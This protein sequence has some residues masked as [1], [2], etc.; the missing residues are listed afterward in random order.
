MS[1]A[2]SYPDLSDH[3]EGNVTP[4]ASGRHSPPIL[5]PPPTTRRTR[6]SPAPTTAELRNEI[7]SLRAIVT[8]LQTRRSRTPVTP[9]ADEFLNPNY[10]RREGTSFSE[11]SQNYPRKRPKVET[12][13]KFDGNVA[14]TRD[15]IVKLSV[16]FALRA[17]DFLDDAEKIAYVFT[18]LEGQAAKWARPIFESPHHPYRKDFDL[19][20]NEFR[21]VFG[22][23][24][25]VEMAEAKLFECRQRST[26]AM[27]VAEFQSLS[28]DVDWNEPALV[29]AFTRGLRSGI[30]DE[31]ARIGRPNKLADCITLACTLDNRLTA[32]AKEISNRNTTGQSSSNTSKNAGQSHA[33]ASSKS[34]IERLGIAF[35][36]HNKS[37]ASRISADT[38]PSL[39]SRISTD[40]KKSS[41]PKGPLSTEEKERRANEG[42]CF[43]CGMKGHLRIDCPLNAKTAAASI[44]VE[45]DGRRQGN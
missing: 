9:N 17:D 34:L 36:E 38:K 19:F 11:S 40:K 16:I 41:V 21:H 29:A 35:D 23:R 22:D 45:I 32:R 5:V 14:K 7:D 4:T 25:V 43:R 10:R 13:S 20:I 44:S 1:V 42:L 3:E 24:E 2:G 12:P 39:E 18:L 31:F 15:F 26:V 27:Y 8:D 6:N 37:L 30:L 28:V 33:K